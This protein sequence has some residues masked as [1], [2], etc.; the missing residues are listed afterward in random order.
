MKTCRFA[1]VIQVFFT[2]GALVPF[3]FGST[4]LGVLSNAV[5]G[6]ITNTLGATSSALV[7]M[8]VGSILIFL[9]CVWFFA[10][11]LAR[12]EPRPVGAHTRAPEKHRGLIL[13]VSR[14]EPCEKAIAYHQPKLEQCWLLCSAQ[15]LSI[16][17]QIQKN[18]AAACT[19]D[20]LVVNDLNNP[21]EVK[22]LVEQIHTQ[23]PSGWSES[24][25][26]VDYTGMTVH[27][28]V[29]AAL[30][31]LSPARHIQYTPAFFDENRN[32]LGSGDP[33]EVR[34]DW[35]L[36]GLAPKPAEARETAT[37]ASRS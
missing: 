32:P 22:Q 9:L 13:L 25:L 30:A 10:N 16:A 12:L 6:L 33:I 14:Q 1:N 28:S 20:P 19:D 18:Y 29:G 23:L 24:D 31:C 27:C 37:A 34:L 17:R 21:L 15:T 5:Y 11:V 4:F 3:L 26:I 36:A 35:E 2:P 8:A 7:A